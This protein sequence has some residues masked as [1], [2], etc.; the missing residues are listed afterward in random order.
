M[1][2]DGFTSWDRLPIAYPG[3]HEGVR[4]TDSVDC[5]MRCLARIERYELARRTVSDR[6]PLHAASLRA[7]DGLATDY[8]A[9][10]SAWSI[11]RTDTRPQ[12]PPVY[13]LCIIVTGLVGPFALLTAAASDQRL[14][15]LRGWPV[16]ALS[17]PIVLPLLFKGL[18][19]LSGLAA[20]SLPAGEA[21]AARRCPDCACDLSDVPP[22]IDPQ[23][24]E[25][26]N[27]GPAACTRCRRPWPLL[28]PPAGAV[29]AVQ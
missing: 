19:T 16:Y 11:D 2:S 5:S 21:L 20:P 28:P 26:Q 22:A 25:Q 1:K 7:C 17:A 8:K 29:K 10:V 3:L 24:L 27:I 23:L 12:F 13:T 14:S 4:G 9:R 6:G 18:S 15:A